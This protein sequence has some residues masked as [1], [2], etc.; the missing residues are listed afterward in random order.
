MSSPLLEDGVAV[1]GS[2]QTWWA[3]V[4]VEITAATDLSQL[5]EFRRMDRGA[6]QQTLLDADRSYLA[7]QL[8][9]LGACEFRWISRRVEPTV[10]LYVLGRTRSGTRES[11][12]QQAASARARMLD[13]PRHVRGRA[14]TSGELAAV[15]D[16]SEVSSGLAELRKRWIVEKA[17]R[18]DF[19]RPFFTSVPW[20]REAP[21]ASWDA[22]L[23]VLAELPATTM[24][25][26]GLEATSLP[27][28]FSSLVTW[29]AA[30]Y[31]RLCQPGERPGVGIF[32]ESVPLGPDPGALTAATLFDD[33]SQ[34]YR[35]QGYDL[36]L[37]V[38][39]AGPVPADLLAVVSEV[40]GAAESSSGG[41]RTAQLAGSP[42]EV[43]RPTSGADAK[44]VLHNLSTLGHHRWQEP[45]AGPPPAMNQIAELQP[46]GRVVDLREATSALRL[47]YALDGTLPGFRVVRPR[48]AG[49]G[50][51][52]SDGLLLGHQEGD[53]QPVRVPLA[54]LTSHALVVGSTGSGKTSSVLNLLEQLWVEHH[55]PFL[56][57]EPVNADRD[58]YRWLLG[59]PGF[60][61]M[62]V[63][64]VGDES[65]AP[66]RLN[67]FE[68]PPGVRVGT[69]AASLVACFDAAFGLTGPLPFLYRKALK[70][71]YERA[72]IS[73]DEVA[74]PRHVGR[75]P[76]LRDLSD[77]FATLPDIDR[78]AGE[79]R[80]NISA[81][82][83]L[84]AESLLNG[85]CGRTLDA[86][87]SFPWDVL[88]SR[89]VVL[90]LAAVGDDDR[91]QALVIAF[92]LNSLTA[93][94]K[95]SRTTSD[96]AHLTVIEEAHRLLRRPRPVGED[97]DQSGRAAEQFANTLAENRKYGEGLVIVEQVPAKLIEDAH[98][99][100]ALKI[101]H[102]LPS[103]DDR[104][105]IAAT[106]NLSED[107][108]TFARALDPMTAFVTHRGLGGQA[109]LV[110]VPNARQVAADARG[111]KEDPLPGRD[112]VRDRFERFAHETPQ[113]WSELAPY[114]ECQ[115]CLHRCQF[116]GIAEV[117]GPRSSAVDA[118]RMDASVYPA[119][120]PERD[121][122]WDEVVAEYETLA[123]EYEE[124][125]LEARGDLAY[126]MFLHSVFAAF[127]G[128]RVDGLARRFRAAAVKQ[129]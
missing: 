46:L 52:S 67:P 65:L 124:F 57:I 116:R 108:Q 6:A 32:T 1:D 88:L 15:R 8:G 106:M 35:D 62:L 83:R 24:L 107:Q 73:T 129:P 21:A 100:T 49:P 29:Y 74:G 55:K 59:R 64:T 71:M 37:T 98:K 19:K 79:V 99:N 20:L 82:S 25:S 78:Y 11:V 9:G 17:Q 39:S 92:L 87:S 113:V 18:S 4:G 60:A 126:C 43:I 101:M 68:A 96:L 66:F 118:A 22:L 90:E 48:S 13:L 27:P 69:H 125:E 89:P 12:L 41:F 47:P 95:A 42:L 2:A 50:V 84:R 44:V 97:G 28:N 111:V 104:D 40:L 34:R 93:Y 54:S 5:N 16:P 85:S 123:G 10:R 75:W 26:V 53:G 31:R 61:S 33:A 121:A 109:G 23:R 56:V 72:G 105:A 103:S 127:P 94:Y 38:A 58:D 91:E 115:P 81:A 128:G 77:V 7:A 102:H 112:V 3:W 70:L 30:E 119:P 63:L 36:R 110:T 51:A 122:L 76:R 114:P 14:L 86:A 117:A 80:S 120:G 45:P